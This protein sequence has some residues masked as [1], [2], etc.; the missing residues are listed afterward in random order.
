MWF[1]EGRRETNE[2]VGSWFRKETDIKRGRGR[3][4]DYM[5]EQLMTKKI[6]KKKRR[7]KNESWREP[8]EPET[9]LF[10]VASQLPEKLIKERTR[11][12]PVII[13]PLCSPHLVTHT[14]HLPGSFQLPDG[15]KLA[16]SHSTKED[17]FHK[18]SRLPIKMFC[19]SKHRLI[20]H[21]SGMKNTN[22]KFYL[23]WRRPTK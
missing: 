18:F 3:P 6:K 21:G 13:F 22:L 17:C 11:K 1:S 4:L 12:S 16:P 20:F 15:S 10:A 14:H 23:W 19:L 7:A 5:E 8:L 9:W 2:H